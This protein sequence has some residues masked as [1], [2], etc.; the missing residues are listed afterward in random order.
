MKIFFSY[1][2][3]YSPTDLK[4]LSKAASFLKK[5]GHITVTD[6]EIRDKNSQRKKL[7]KSKYQKDI[8]RKIKDSDVLITEVH[9]IDAKLG[10]EIAK[11]L[12]EKKIVIILQ[13]ENKLTEEIQDSYILNKKNKS[14]IKKK[15]TEK[16]IL[17]VLESATKE[18][19]NRMDT[20]FILIISPEIDRYLD[21]SSKNKRMHKAQVVREA[22]DKMMSKDKEY[23]E[24]LKS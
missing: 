17:S 16:N 13:N 19:K 11:A 14:L 15:Y 5:K 21:W 10:Y 24:Y 18:A 7:D 4:F 23:N 1:P 8:E 9:F 2:D 6:E 12:D 3:K 22:V 20:K